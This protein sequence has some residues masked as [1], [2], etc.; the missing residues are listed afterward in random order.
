MNPISEAYKLAYEYSPIYFTGGL[1]SSW[2][3]ALGNSIGLP[4]IAITEAL[5]VTGNT[6]NGILSGS[7]VTLPA[8]PFFTWRPLPGGTLWKSE[9]AEFPFYTN[10]IAANSQVQQP[11][12]ISMLG[13]CPASNSA[14][15]TVKLATMEALQAFIQVHV[16]NGGTFSVATPSYIYTNCLLTQMTDV[17]QGESNQSQVSWQLDFTQPLLTFGGNGN[18]L[19]GLLTDISGG[20]TVAPSLPSI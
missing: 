15:F 13:H 5:S 12:N 7:N 3:T 10:Q 14:P 20:S 11:L 16:N 8:Q 19:S 9:I 4:I 2:S 17:S 1:I 6:I 18:V